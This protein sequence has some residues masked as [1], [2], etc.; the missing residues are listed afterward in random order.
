MRIKDWKKFQHFKDRRPPWIKLYRDLLDDPQYHA[1]DGESAKML[2]LLWLLAS[3]FDG[4]LPDI[5]VISFRLR[6]PEEKVKKQINKLNHW[7]A[8]DDINVISTGNQNDTPEK[9]TEG[10][11]E[12][13]EDAPSG[14]VLPDW[15]PVKEWNYWVAI[16][17]KK[18]NKPETLQK[19]IEKLDAWRKKG[20]S[21]KE[22]LDYSIAG[23]YQGLFEPKS[24]S[25]D[26]PSQAKQDDIYRGVKI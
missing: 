16:R 5:G 20:H 1:L 24:N 11:K 22:I 21:V 15:V 23:G 17:P 19:N 9:E 8:S 3:E 18:S 14:V 26:K 10:E 4:N 2:T 13:E 12:R 6:M 25:Y 7:L